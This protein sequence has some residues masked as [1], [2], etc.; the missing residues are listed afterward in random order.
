MF[1]DAGW[2][3][4]DIDDLSVSSAAHLMGVAADGKLHGDALAEA[5]QAAAEGRA[6]KLTPAAAELTPADRARLEEFR[7]SR[8]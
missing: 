5:N 1:L 7:A 8:G 2:R 4:S 3:E 6:P